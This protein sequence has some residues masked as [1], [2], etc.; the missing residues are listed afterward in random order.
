VESHVNAPGAI[1]LFSGHGPESAW[2]NLDGS[3]RPSSG[4]SQAPAG[5]RQ[6]PKTKGPAPTLGGQ[7]GR[8]ALRPPR[9]K[10]PPR[11]FCPRSL[12]R[13]RGRTPATS[14][15]SKIQTST[16]EK[17]WDL[18]R[19]GP[20]WIGNIFAP[21]P[22][23]KI[24]APS[25]EDNFRPVVSIN[26]RRFDY[27]EKKFFFP[28]RTKRQIR[29]NGNPRPDFKGQNWVRP[30]PERVEVHEPKPPKIP[31]PICICIRNFFRD[32]TFYPREERNWPAR[33]EPMSA[34]PPFVP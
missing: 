32:G 27:C 21:G 22:F 13:R 33:A 23:L 34:W 11:L 28:R 3:P 10:L 29:S 1:F 31:L 30:G 5:P 4:N 15:T 18:H 25:G 6:L 7:K 12:F 17:N 16:P 24:A 26:E 8:F 19:I 2:R 20:W 14:S 9:R